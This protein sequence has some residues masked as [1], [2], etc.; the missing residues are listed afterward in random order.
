MRRERDQLLQRLGRLGE[1]LS[2]RRREA[3]GLR[4]PGGEFVG[5][6]RAD[7]GDLPGLAGRPVA[8]RVARWGGALPQYAVG[9]VGR[10]DRVRAAVAKVPGLAVCGAA[11]EGVGIAACVAL[12]R[13][14]AESVLSDQNSPAGEPGQAP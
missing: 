5:R 12:A 7:L 3:G 14:A 6:V 4:R 13:I 9:H 1:L 8:A 2:Q 10:M 11:Y